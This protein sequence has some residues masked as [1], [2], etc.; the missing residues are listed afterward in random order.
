MQTINSYIDLANKG[1]LILN[2]ENDLQGV[3]IVGQQSDRASTACIA[4]ASAA[5]ILDGGGPGQAKQVTE[6]TVESA[7]S[8]TVQPLAAELFQTEELEELD[9]NGVD[10]VEDID[11]DVVSDVGAGE[12]IASDNN[13]DASVASSGKFTES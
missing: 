7:A 12:E 11:G 6:Q 2:E 5:D 3:K 10:V 8:T 1:K 9:I 4:I 13:S